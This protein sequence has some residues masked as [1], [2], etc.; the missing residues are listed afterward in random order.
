[1]IEQQLSTCRFS[2]AKVVQRNLHISDDFIFL[3]L[4]ILRLLLLVFVPNGQE[5][6]L[7]FSEQNRTGILS[8][9][10]AGCLVD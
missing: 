3:G 5:D 6:K 4:F 2:N 9:H 10:T 8:R 7:E 1:M